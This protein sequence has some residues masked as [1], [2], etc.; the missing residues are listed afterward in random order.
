MKSLFRQYF[1]Y[2]F[3][4]VR[5]LQKHP[6]QMSL[7]QFIPPL[8]AACLVAGALAAPFSAGARFGLLGILAA[9]AL[10]NIVA[11][12]SAGR[13]GPVPQVFVLPVVYATLHV[14]YG[15]GFLAGL[16]HFR[17]RWTRTAAVPPAPG[18]QE[19]SA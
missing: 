2:G 1:Q 3:W 19:D 6:R 5:V 9:Y 15:F 4:K 10:A 12:L 7:R 17:N 13:Q 11:S 16:F 18:R 8:F 14:S